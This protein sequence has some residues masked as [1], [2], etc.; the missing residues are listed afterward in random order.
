MQINDPEYTVI[1]SRPVGL[2]ASMVLRKTYLLLSLTILFSA[3][4]AMLPM[5]GL[6]PIVYSPLLC[7][8]GMFALLF[9]AQ[10]TSHSEWGVF[11]TFAF[12]GF[13]GYT[14]A[15]T[16]LYYLSAY[17]NGLALIT[18]S[19]FCTAVVFMAL[20]VYTVYSGADFS[21]LGGMLFVGITTALLLSI[22]GMFWQVE[23]FSVIVAGF[24]MLIVSGLIM[25][26]TSLIVNGGE[27]NYVL[28]TIGLYVSILN[29]FLS[30]LRILGFL[31][32]SRRN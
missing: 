5:F 13:M 23:W 15:P 20:S 19:L 26:R 10:S 24:F 1:S 28:A 30:I 16:L 3:V 18:M 11:W 31:A 29:L 7:I 32:G 4:A 9:I 14:L 17:N 25:F 27:R 12:T 22:A 2:E 6:L 8:V 21:Y